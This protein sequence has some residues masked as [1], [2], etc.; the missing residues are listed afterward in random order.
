MN[1]PFVFA[2][3]RKSLGLTQE[4]F[5]EKCGATVRS[6]QNWEQGATITPQA[7]KLFRYIEAEMLSRKEEAYSHNSVSAFGS[8]VRIGSTEQ[9]TYG[10]NSPA[11]NGDNNHFGG[12]A[13]I[14]RAFA[15]IDKSLAQNEAV[16]K[17]LDSALAEIAEQ[18]K[19]VAQSMAQTAMLIQ[20]LQNQK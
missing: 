10:D 5:A 15:T 2:E 8:D 17:T 14:D 7:M 20:L 6:V 19:L 9:T 16:L 1:N 13:S 11:V 12:C 4:E 3:F 18:R